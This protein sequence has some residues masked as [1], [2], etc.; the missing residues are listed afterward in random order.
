MVQM[1][2]AGAPAFEQA[3]PAMLA[4]ASRRTVQLVLLVSPAN[5]VY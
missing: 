3:A 1:K 4:L 5:S 2:Y